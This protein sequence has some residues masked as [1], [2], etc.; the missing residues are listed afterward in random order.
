ML[1]G[2][3]PALLWLS[4]APAALSPCAPGILAE[5]GAAL[6]SMSTRARADGDIGPAEDSPF[7]TTLHI[8]LLG[9]AP[10]GPAVWVEVTDPD[11]LGAEDV[12]QQLTAGRTVGTTGP[13]LLL[14]FAGS[15]PG[16][17]TAESLVG[18]QAFTE[19]SLLGGRDLDHLALIGSGGQILAEWTPSGD[20]FDVAGVV[21]PGRWLVAA[22][23]D[24][25]GTSFAVTAPIWIDPTGAGS[26]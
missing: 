3:L 4:A 24:D 1:R 21:Q 8:S 17:R 14:Q 15:L 26:G 9:L 19:I 13:L 16:D 25:L 7:L 22:A 6:A 20:T 5:F 11:L 10:M 23:W 2:V 18:L 12:E